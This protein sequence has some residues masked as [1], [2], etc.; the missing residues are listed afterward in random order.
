MKKILVRLSTIQWGL[1]ALLLTGCATASIPVSTEKDEFFSHWKKK[2]DTSKGYI[3]DEIIVVQEDLDNQIILDDV[4][5]LEVPS[6]PLPTMP[7]N[8]LSMNE[9]VDVSSFLRALARQADQNIFFSENVKGAVRFRLNSASTWDKVFLATLRVH[10][11]TYAWEGDIIRVMAKSDLQQD[12]EM[13]EIQE[14]REAVENAKKRVEPLIVQTVRIRF[15]DAR[16]LRNHLEMLLTRNDSNNNSAGSNERRGSVTVDVDNNTIV[17]NAIA[18]DISK[19]MKLINR[20]D[21]ATS[22]ILIEANIVEANKETARE[23]GVQWGGM[24]SAVGGN[25]L[26][27][28]N[29]GANPAGMAANFPA[30]FVPGT[31]SGLTL[32]FIAQRLGQDQLLKLQLSAL[33]KEGLLNILSSPSITTLDNQ[34]AYIESG[35][36]VP[37]QVV[38]GTGESKDLTTEWKKALLR[39]EVTPNVIDNELL[40][41]K[42]T[43][44]KDELDE[45]VTSQSGLP[46]IITKKAETTLVLYD[47]QTTVIGG[48]TKEVSRDTESGIPF[49]RSIPLL[50]Y[51]FK[52]RGTGST[53]EDLL[54]FITPHILSAPALSHDVTPV[55]YELQNIETETSVEPAIESVLTSPED[56]EI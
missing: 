36:E 39:L 27:S 38:S 15:S 9:S 43:T 37:Y 44:N 12:L 5:N 33:E 54:I 4:E 41:L 56:E 2:A 32:G 53:M 29:A 49:L 8:S 42:I 28:A 3:H 55:S 6:R 31:E 46:R 19:M 40:K 24:Y 17:M 30:S 11:L 48:L 1:V 23:L 52:G 14:R 21:R 45:S 50:G 18:D 47:G 35:K 26:Y 34:M 25:N 22:Q 13:E 51:L 7:I 16:K 20:L 10:G